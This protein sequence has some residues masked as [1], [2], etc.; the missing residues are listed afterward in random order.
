MHTKYT[1]KNGKRFGPY[2]YE[3]KRV[4]D[5]VV[6]TYLGK[7][8][9]GEPKKNLVLALAVLFLL[10]SVSFFVYEKVFFTGKATLDL[11]SI[12]SSGELVAGEAKIMLKHGELLP[13]SSTVRARL[14]SQEQE[15]SLSSLI[16]QS[17]ESGEFFI[18]NTELT[19][20]G[21]GYGIKGSKETF[22]SVYFR[23]KIE[24]TIEKKSGYKI[25]EEPQ[26]PSQPE[27]TGENKKEQTIG[28]TGKVIE[29]EFIDASVNAL[30]N[31]S[32]N[33]QENE[34]ASIE[35]ES[36]R[37]ESEDL[38]DDAVSLVIENGKA[39]VS[40]EYSVEERGFGQEYLENE[41]FIFTIDVFQFN[42]ESEAGTLEFEISYKN[43][44]LIYAEKNI[45][46]KEP[47]ISIPEQNVTELPE[48]NIT[49]ENITSKENLSEGISLKNVTIETKVSKI[50]LGQP[51]KWTKTILSQEAESFK[52]ELPKEAENISIKRKDKE[53]K[54]E[55]EVS[56]AGITGN[57]IVLGQESWISQFLKR[58][59]R[60]TGLVVSGDYESLTAVE[61][62]N[63]IELDLYNITN[64]Y[65]IEY[66][67][68]A[69]EISQE[70]NTGLEKIVIVSA[71]DN[72]GY[73]DV[74]T[75]TNLSMKV[76]DTSRIRVY[77]RNYDY[78]S[79][80]NI[81]I[82]RVEEVE[83]ES[84][85][86]EGKEFEETEIAEEINESGEANE[87]LLNESQSEEKK[88]GVIGITGLSIEGNASLNETIENITFES[89]ETSNQTIEETNETLNQTL[90][91]EINESEAIEN[92]SR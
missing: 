37:T 48:E 31:F 88:K 62:N 1:Y 45:V 76:N 17:T 12:A 8:S 7:K 9:V 46:G 60:F 86:R 49:Q 26:E 78:N 82:K 20:S 73:K 54:V 44:S 91:E 68:P 11:S 72:L 18:R 39:I 33:L 57:V 25:P 38:A 27:Q 87:T 34:E 5:K 30:E 84:L 23:L 21:E 43:I 61:T 69:P 3:N 83:N 29:T 59:L 50:I 67:T 71:P 19:G 70:T 4:D 42:L 90:P 28:I 89:N 24:R 75:F 56:K 47:T 15:K 40:T 63:A 16:S 14:N 92:G 51:V 36:V 85:V 41:T 77:W 55:V 32:Y 53:E 13:A 65:E 6:T 35:Q 64:N 2:F 10:F 66:Y 52:L 80:K 81:S 58:V 22:P 74:I 79:S